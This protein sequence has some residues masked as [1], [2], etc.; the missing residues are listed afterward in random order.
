MGLSNKKE[1]QLKQMPRIESGFTKSKD[2]KY[3]IHKTTITTI[4]P[5]QYFEKVLDNEGTAEVQMNLGSE[6]LE[7]SA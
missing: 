2:G 7:E 5:V 3:I 6:F 4:R 1:E